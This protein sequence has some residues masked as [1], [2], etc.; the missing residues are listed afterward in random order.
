MLPGNKSV[1]FP[2]FGLHQP[3]VTELIPLL[4]IAALSYQLVYVTLLHDM[5]TVSFTGSVGLAVLECW[6]IFHV[7][8]S[9]SSWLM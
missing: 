3:L 1:P 2:A 4:M 9:D 6:N 7:P 5:L 8:C